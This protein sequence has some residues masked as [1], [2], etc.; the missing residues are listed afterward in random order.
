[1]RGTDIEKIASYLELPRSTVVE[2]YLRL[3]D[4]SLSLLE[5]PNHDCVFWSDGCTVYEARPGQC[6]TYPFWSS[7]LESTDRWA[8]EAR[9]CEGIGQGPTYDLVA[10]GRLVRGAGGTEDGPPRPL[11]SAP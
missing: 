6:R 3:V 11:G 10:I 1:M 7:N 8:R 5:K 4:G 2:R 9:D